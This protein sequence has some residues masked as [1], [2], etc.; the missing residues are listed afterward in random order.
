VDVVRVLL[1]SGADV[2]IKT[3]QGRHTPLH[4]ACQIG[5]LEIVRD[6]IKRGANVRGA[7]AHGLTPT[8]VTV[9]GR[10]GNPRDRQLIVKELIKA[11]ADGADQHKAFGGTESPMSRPVSALGNIG[12]S[13]PPVSPAT[14]TSS[15]MSSLS[16]QAPAGSVR[17]SYEADLGAHDRSTPRSPSEGPLGYSTSASTPRVTSP[18]SAIGSP[19]SSMM[20]LTPRSV[21]LQFSPAAIDAERSERASRMITA[22]RTSSSNLSPRPPAS[23]RTPM[24]RTSAIGS[25]LRGQTPSTSPASPSRTAASPAPYLL[26][27]QATTSAV[28]TSSGDSPRSDPA[29]ALR[30]ADAKCVRELE[31][32]QARAELQAAKRKER[33]AAEEEVRKS[34]VAQQRESRALALAAYDDHT[35]TATRKYDPDFVDDEALWNSSFGADIDGDWKAAEAE[36]KQQREETEARLKAE[37]LAR[38]TERKQARERAETEMRE[39]RAAAA[40]ELESRQNAAAEASAARRQQDA[41]RRSEEAAERKA[42]EE[43]FERRRA[44]ATA[45]RAERQSAVSSVVDDDSGGGV[46][47]KLRANKLAAEKEAAAFA[48]LERERAEKLLEQRRAVEARAKEEAELRKAHEEERERLRQKQA[49]AR[50]ELAKMGEA[51]RQAAQAALDKEREQAEAA[52]A[53][54]AAEMEAAADA[55]KQAME[56]EKQKQE[57]D[58]AERANARVREEE[59]AEA[60]RQAKIAER[61]VRFNPI[62]IRF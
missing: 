54:A 22:I 48:Q 40:A 61:Q 43:E 35:P 37:R 51:E 46:F 13:P 15:V 6:L 12:W 29:A 60:E 55:A 39:A 47:A 33:N 2:H 49:A 14:R 57:Q 42:A 62:L 21:S 4:L 59:E 52:M 32:R 53:A 1:A 9:A 23:P 58:K 10:S 3:A 34:R 8:A 56:E 31:Q 28:R 20:T 19:G 24:R 50:A 7:D 41:A 16:R 25:P 38:E 17:L 18:L 26:R 11:G 36:A 45:A 44:D 30:E 27:L 5:C